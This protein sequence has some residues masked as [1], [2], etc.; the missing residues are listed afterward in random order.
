MAEPS[1]P[2]LPSGPGPILPGGGRIG[3]GRIDPRGGQIG[4]DRQP[5]GGAGPS[6]PVQAGLIALAV[7][8]VGTAVL[9]AATGFLWASLAPRAL[10]VVVARG[11]A[12][13]VNPETNAFIAADGWFT[14]LTAAGG[15]V[16]GLLGYALA[17]RRHGALAMTGVLAG[18]LA[19]TLIAMWIGQR[20][21][22]AAFKHGLASDRPGTLLHVPLA[23]GGRGPLA[24][25]PLAAGLTAGVIEL[26]VLLRERRR[27]HTPLHAYGPQGYGAAAAAPGPNG[28]AGP[29]PGR[30]APLHPFA[31]GQAPRAQDGHPAP[32]GPRGREGSGPDAPPRMAGPPEPGPAGD[33]RD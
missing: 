5:G 11:S 16:S 28:F 20:S 10:A 23:L 19:A 22:A 1:Q 30:T 18:A 24:F 25:W 2:S 33:P 27:R 6:H 31:P 12:N 29:V 17:V 4:S 21:G 7:V 32:G 8:I 14:L 15:I 13:V 9:G 3:G 26:I